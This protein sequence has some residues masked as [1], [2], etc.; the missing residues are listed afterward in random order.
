MSEQDLPVGAC[1]Q[2]YAEQR[3]LRIGNRLYPFV[4]GGLTSD[5]GAE[6]PNKGTIL[7]Q[8]QPNAGVV[9]APA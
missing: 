1:R 3:L 4:I 5:S 8:A 6:W 9:T 2:V 7:R